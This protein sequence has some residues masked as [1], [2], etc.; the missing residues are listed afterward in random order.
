MMGI[1]SPLAEKSMQ[2]SAIAFCREN[3]ACFFLR[4]QKTEIFFIKKR[5][6]VN[7]LLKNAKNQK[8]KLKRPQA[9]LR[10]CVPET[11]DVA[12]KS[13]RQKKMKKR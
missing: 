4:M 12:A 6:N 7:Y 10:W 11:Q 9:I 8:E 3:I 1:L 5:V 2:I 13:G